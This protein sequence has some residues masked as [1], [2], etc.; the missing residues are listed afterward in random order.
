MKM[1]N[2]MKMMVV[3]GGLE[4]F[5]IYHSFGGAGLDYGKKSKIEY[6]ITK[7]FSYQWTIYTKTKYCQ[8]YKYK[9]F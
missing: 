2:E 6:N 8:T 5:M 3:D 4:G 7:Q 9:Q 1:M